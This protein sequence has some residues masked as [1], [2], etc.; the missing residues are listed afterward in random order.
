MDRSVE[1]RNASWRAESDRNAWNRER[2]DWQP[3]DNWRNRPGNEADRN[4]AGAPASGHPIA[5]RGGWGNTGGFSES[6]YNRGISPNEPGVGGLEALESHWPA[7]QGRGRNAPPNADWPDAAPR[8]AASAAADAERDWGRDE[9]AWSR[10]QGGWGNAAPPNWSS[11]HAGIADTTWG[12]GA[13]T[14]RR[15]RDWGDAGSS[16][17]RGAAGR[18]WGAQPDWSAR[19]ASDGPFRGRGPQGYQRS[20]ERIREDICDLLTERGDV[21]ASAVQVRVDN[22][23]VTLEGSVP[24]RRMKRIAE[25]VADAARGVRDVH[26]RLRVES[27]RGDAR[28]WNQGAWSSADRSSASDRSSSRGANASARD[29]TASS[30]GANAS[31][32]DAN[33]SSRGANASSRGANASPRGSNASSRGASASRAPTG[34]G[35]SNAQGR[36]SR[37]A[38]GRGASNAAGRGASNA[39]GRA[40]NASGR[41]GSRSSNTPNARDRDPN[42][43][44]RG[45][46][47]RRGGRN[48]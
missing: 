35:S 45:G 41:S 13:Y 31:A 16:W 2:D 23:E 28:A 17:S 22:R 38:A 47:S 42:A 40:S 11:Q 44:A 33:A 8:S 39:S 7:P 36:S 14:S 21:D 9:R 30:R 15:E 18:E 25:D 48:R 43:P 27:D 37:S 26:N 19:D 10:R 34:R 1:E 46:S 4:A 12:G 6:F 20:D 29:A 3:S 32:R 24:D 5:F